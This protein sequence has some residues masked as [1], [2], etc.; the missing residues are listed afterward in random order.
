MQQSFPE[1]SNRPICLFCAYLKLIV[2]QI[3]LINSLKMC[4]LVFNA[5]KLI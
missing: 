3:L 1:L 5:R 4:I 2:F